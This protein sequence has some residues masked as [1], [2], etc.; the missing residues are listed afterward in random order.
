MLLYCP[1]AWNG[2]SR[3]WAPVSAIELLSATCGQLPANWLALFFRFS[4]RHVSAEYWFAVLQPFWI[5][6]LITVPGTQKH[7]P[8]VLLPLSFDVLTLL[9][10]SDL[11]FRRHRSFSGLPLLLHLLVDQYLEHHIFFRSIIL[12]LQLGNK[13]APEVSGIALRHVLS[14]LWP[15][16]R[17]YLS[18]WEHAHFVFTRFGTVEITSAVTKHSAICLS[19]FIILFPAATSFG[20]TCSVRPH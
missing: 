20:T 11:L 13:L 15:K 4:F 6:T 7:A 1:S 10:L 17:L 14:V 9:S 16:D 5:F 12:F 18:R 8:W 3:W 19:C 2:A